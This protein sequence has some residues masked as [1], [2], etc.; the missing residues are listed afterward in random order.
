MVMQLSMHV[1]SS[2]INKSEA[3]SRFVQQGTG[4]CGFICLVALESG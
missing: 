1:N 3:K 4:K 2:N